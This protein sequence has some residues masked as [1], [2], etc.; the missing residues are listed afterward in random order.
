[1]GH[2]NNHTTRSTRLDK[3]GV[4]PDFSLPDRDGRLYALSAIT[5][6]YAIVYFYPKDN[7]PG[8]TIEAQEFQRTLPAL[9]Q[10]GASIIGIGGG[11][12]KSK[13]S[14]C[15]K[16][17]LTFPLLSDP[18]FSVCR[19]WG[20]YGPKQ[21]MGRTFDGIHRTTF[22]LDKDKRLLKRYDDV[23][24][25]GHAQDVLSYLGEVSA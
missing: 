1:M 12:E 6:P 10:L 21:F 19:R 20:V 2:T 9:T 4:A 16:H 25:Q 22:L 3:G 5:T 15:E 24:A 11:D 17:G 13:A 14:F 18:G 8:C 7:T 23:K